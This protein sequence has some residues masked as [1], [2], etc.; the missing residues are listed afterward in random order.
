MFEPASHQKVGPS[1][2]FHH[3]RER[4]FRV[5]DLRCA[6]ALTN[7]PPV[8]DLID[9]P[10]AGPHDEAGYSFASHM[11]APCREGRP[12]RALWWP[13]Q[14]S[15]SRRSKAMPWMPIGISVR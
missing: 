14:A 13:T 2:L 8:D 6:S 15:S 5:F 11:F 9:V 7:S 1:G 4:P 10:Y 12:L 3:P